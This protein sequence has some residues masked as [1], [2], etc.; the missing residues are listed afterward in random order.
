[1]GPLKPILKFFKEL[2]KVLKENNIS[3]KIY[4]WDIQAKKKIS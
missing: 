4:D 1:V 3:A 2:D